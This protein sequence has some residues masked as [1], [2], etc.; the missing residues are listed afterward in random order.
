MEG[1]IPAAVAVASAAELLV[2]L[3]QLWSAE[4][5][6]AVGAGPP[7]GCPDRCGNVQVPFPFGIRD[8][9]F[10]AGFGL[11]CDTTRNPPRL[12][13]GDGTLQ[14]VNISLASYTVHAIDTAGA[15]NVSYGLNN[16]TGT[17]GHGASSSPATAR[18]TRTWFPTSSTS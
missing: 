16:G 6:V 15:A 4:A 2:L 5:Q 17:W 1:M 7:P 11:T 10:L 9:C 13:V 18:L 14:V 8:G 12:M 3:L